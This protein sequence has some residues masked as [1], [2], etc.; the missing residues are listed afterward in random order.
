MNNFV[1]SDSTKDRKLDKIT[2]RFLQE[3][4][5]NLI[6][7]AEQPVE[8]QQKQWATYGNINLWFDTWEKYLVKIGLAYRHD[9]EK[10]L[11][12]MRSPAF[13]W[14]VLKR[15]VEEDCQYDPST[16]D[17]HIMEDLTQ[18]QCNNYFYNWKLSIRRGTASSF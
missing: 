13:P 10:M 8:Y 5:I 4:S 11:F 2:I 17:Y 14:T 7:K 16:C 6:V 12:L 9:K 18:N 15:D 1:S 3:T